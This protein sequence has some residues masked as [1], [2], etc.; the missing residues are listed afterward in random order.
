[1]IF[2]PILPQE[3]DAVLSCI[4]PDPS[5]MLSAD[6]VRSRLAD[7][8]YRPEWIWVAETG[9]GRAPLLLAIWWGMPGD[10]HPRSLDGLFSTAASSV[11]SRPDARTFPPSQPSGDPR[12]ATAAALLTAAHQAFAADGLTALPE[13]HLFLPPSWRD[14][15]ETAAA[16][17]WRRE[18]SKAA[19]LRVVTERL[20]FE[21]TAEGPVP[22]VSER[23]V[24]TPEPD[25]EVFVDLLR[26]TLPGSLD[27]ATTREALLVGPEEQARNDVAFYR[28]DML[29]E[30]SWWRIARM[31]TGQVVGFGIPSRNCNTSVVG[32][33]GVLPEFRGRGFVAEIL[34]EIT[35]ILATEA[36]ET[37]VR[38]DT[39]LTNHPMIAAFELLGYSEIARRLVLSAG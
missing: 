28:H 16:V 8:E 24:F 17:K 33:L 27:A 38:A 30:R 4:Q 12:S 11:L 9:P 3:L 14:Q 15:P 32:Y 5:T 29:G 1:M 20:R 2:R 23:L 31:S 7:G 35:R 19:G 34:A 36:K 26:R 6:V 25:D 13:Y 22:S 18:A 10:T 37:V 21:W 39:D